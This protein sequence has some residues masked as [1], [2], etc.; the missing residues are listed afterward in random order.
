[1]EKGITEMKPG[2]AIMDPEVY[3]A[4]RKKNALEP[5]AGIKGA[6]FNKGHYNLVVKNA[7]F[8]SV[9]VSKGVEP[10]SNS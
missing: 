7:A 8:K 5:I 10:V 6:T 1:M 3:L 2:F 9:A 4:L